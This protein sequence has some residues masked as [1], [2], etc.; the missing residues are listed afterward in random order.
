MIPSMAAEA[1][2]RHR[3]GGHRPASG[4][5]AA[6]TELELADYDDLFVPRAIITGV[7]QSLPAGPRHPLYR[8]ILGSAW[9]RLPEPIRAMHDLSGDLTVEGRAKVERGHGRA[10]R[11]IAALFRFPPATGDDVPVQVRFHSDGR[12]ETWQRDF[13]GHKFSSIQEE[14][15]G[16]FERLLCERF[17][18]FAFGL[19]LVL[20]EARLKLVVRGW[21]LVRHS[22]A[23]GACAR[24]RGLRIRGQRS[25]QFRC[26]N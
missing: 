13:A 22:A 3:L 7:R 14:G 2:I 24:R 21:S 6:T 15:R 11:L 8:R 23:I 4:A 17:G 10:A 20:Q 25:L 1:I 5:R 9:H 12:R 16:R 19:A 18:P 26:R